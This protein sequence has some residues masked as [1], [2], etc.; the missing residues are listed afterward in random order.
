MTFEQ[1]C[2][3][4]EKFIYKVNSRKFIA[5]TTATI[6]LFT[7]YLDQDNWLMITLLWLGVQGFLDYK[8]TGEPQ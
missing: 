2:Q 4:I 7:Q 1:V 8:K 5:W 3:H 6:A